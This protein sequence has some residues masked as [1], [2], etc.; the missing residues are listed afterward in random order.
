MLMRILDSD[1]IS[2][3]KVWMC[4]LSWVIVGNYWM[5]EVRLVSYEVSC[6]FYFLAIDSLRES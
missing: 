5:D 3:D 4:Y 6:Y 2:W 1:V